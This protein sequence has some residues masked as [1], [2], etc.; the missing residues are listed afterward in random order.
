MWKDVNLKN[1]QCSG[2][3]NK[4]IKGDFLSNDFQFIAIRLKM[5]EGEKCA[6]KSEMWDFF[7]SDYLSVMYIDTYTDSNDPTVPVKLFVENRFAYTLKES[8]K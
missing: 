6:N 5:C 8:Q 3:F 7:K 2:A 1:K 4:T